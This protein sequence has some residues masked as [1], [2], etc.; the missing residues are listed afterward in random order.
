MQ[1]VL[2]TIASSKSSFLVTINND[3]EGN[4]AT[5]S[6]NVKIYFNDYSELKKK[7]KK[8]LSS[9]DI[10]GT[11]DKAAAS[12]PDFEKISKK[13]LASIDINSKTALHIEI[14]GDIHILLVSCPS[15]D[16]DEVL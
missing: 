15:P 11:T 1:N 2:L 5:S 4:S 10:W 12:V 16:I 13:L 14:S 8:F 6:K 7:L 9:V 3:S